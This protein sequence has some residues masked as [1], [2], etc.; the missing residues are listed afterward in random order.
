MDDERSTGPDQQAG[1]PQTAH[2]YGVP[3][4]G[5]DP[6]GAQPHAQ[7]YAGQHHGATAYGTQQYGPQ[8]YAAQP[9]GA[10]PYGA[11]PHGYPGYPGYP[12]QGSAPGS[13]MG[14]AGFVLGLLG[15]LLCWIPGIGVICATLGIIFGSV[16]MNQLKRVGGNTGLAVTGLVLGILGALLFVLFLFAWSSDP[17]YY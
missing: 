16:G 4:Y 2:P 11:A 10:Q 17:Y 1:A 15:V 12:Q 5:A 14:V 8:Q 3:S 6:Y 9:Y 7:P 13:G